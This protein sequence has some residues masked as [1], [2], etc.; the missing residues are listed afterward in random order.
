[1]NRPE[2]C[3]K[4]I[5]GMGLM[6]FA[7][8]VLSACNGKRSAESHESIAAATK[9]EAHQRD[10]TVTVIDQNGRA[11][12]IPKKVNRVVMLPLPLPAM[13][14]AI[15]GSTKEIAGVAPSSKSNMRKSMLGVIAPSLLTV[16]TGFIKGT[17]IN[18][19][20][21][22]N[23]KPDLIFFW[24][25]Y[26]KQLAQLEA[27]NIPAVGVFTFKGKSPLDA[28]HLWM[29]LLGRIFGEW[30]KASSLIAY[31]NKTADEIYS[32]I[33]GIPKAKKPRA[34][35]IYN[36]SSRDITVPGRGV[37]IQSWLEVTGAVNAAEN[38]RGTTSV[39]MEQIYK[40]D[41]DIIYI[42]NF[43]NTYP[44]D[45]INN[46]IERQDWGKVRAVREGRV[47]KIPSGIYRWCPPSA[48]ASLMLKWLAQNHHPALFND[49][50]MS[51]EIRRHFAEFYHHDLS[52]AQIDSILHPTRAGM[53]KSGM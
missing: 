35:I 41:P 1:M 24:G 18:I 5:C 9:D 38:A 23:I 25:L 15:T 31:N 37:Y 47:Y 33:R 10:E 14:Y 20:E 28:I 11:V 27:V 42:S 48:D 13:Y 49:Y 36:H 52:P 21:L 43:C 53:V 3:R 22:L 16:P 45:L 50:K 40:W 30:E 46:T 26:P 7:L 12:V 34:I 44:S 51:D 29:N 39:N 2:M 4:L 8:T 17:D 32:R 6:L 19:E